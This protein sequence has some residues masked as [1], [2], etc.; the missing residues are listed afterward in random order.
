MIPVYKLCSRL[1]LLLCIFS[2]C[3]L[4]TPPSC[5]QTPSLKG[6]VQLLES[7]PEIEVNIFN[8]LM[9]PVRRYLKERMLRRSKTIAVKTFR[10]GDS[11]IYSV[12][13]S[14]DGSKIA[15]G[16]MENIIKICD[17]S[18]NKL[19]HSLNVGRENFVRSVC[20][21]PDGSRLASGVGNS[22]KIWNV[23]T[24]E[25][26]QT[27]QGHRNIVTSVFYHPD[28]SKL[29][30]GSYDQTI[31]IWDLQSGEEIQTFRGHSRSVK[32]ISLSPDGLKLASGSEDNTVRIWDVKTG[33]ELH[34]FRGHTN[35]VV[36]VSFSPDGEKIASGSEDYSVKIWDLKTDRELQTLYHDRRVSSVA[37]SKEGLLVSVSEHSDRK[38]EAGKINLW[39]Q[40]G[41]ELLTLQNLDDHDFQSVV[42]SP[43][44]MK[45]ATGGYGGRS[46]G[47]VKIWN[48][49]NDQDRKIL[50]ILD[51]KW[52]LSAGQKLLLYVLYRQHQHKPSKKI[53][54]TQTEQELIE[55]YG[56]NPP[57]LLKVKESYEGLPLELKNLVK[58][59]FNVTE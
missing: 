57:R 48:L 9:T 34:T 7:Y 46:N 13:F 16:S 51:A 39:D 54:L 25:E 17:L 55:E 31:K 27:L 56:S 4:G 35:G 20:F 21:S 41:R 15:S 58:V 26:T 18:T 53:D 1:I 33:K 43:D 45:L 44:G 22:I 3:F 36:S 50:D 47:I 28:T 30:S 52:T 5:A 19:I 8:R 32:A 12:C 40:T 29:I 38:R 37:Y 42:F 11:Y 2:L 6:I 49:F 14:P 10:G 24:G 23:A 59:A